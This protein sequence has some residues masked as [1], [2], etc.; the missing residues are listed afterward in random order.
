M[1]KDKIE[2]FKVET[3]LAKKNKTGEVIFKIARDFISHLLEK[4]LN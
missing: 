3:R 1:S 4:E 2:S